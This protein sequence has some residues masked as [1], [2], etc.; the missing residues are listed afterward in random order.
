VKFLSSSIAAML[1]TLSVASVFG[2]AAPGAA[3]AAPLPPGPDASTAESSASAGA[4]A[5]AQTSNPNLDAQLDAARR[6]LEEAARQVAELS[7][8]R[9]Q[10]VI[11]QYSMFVNGPGRAIIG[12][13][14][15]NSS[16]SGTG[17][18]SGGARVVDVSPGGPAAEAGIR[19]GDV[20]TAVNG[21]DVK[22]ADPARQ[23][24]RLVRDVKPESKVRIEVSRN[25]KAQQFTLTARRGPGF[26]FF[27]PGPEGL[28][29]PPAPAAPP[30]PPAFPFGPGAMFLAQGPLADMELATLTPRLGSY[31]GTDKG[32]LVVRAPEDGA[33]KLEDGDV[34][35]SI[36][37]RVPTSGPHATRILASYQPGEK[38]N[39]RVVRERK[40]MDI[41]ATMPDRP[42][43]A[44]NRVYFR[45]GGFSAPQTRG[46]VIIM[47]G[48]ES[49]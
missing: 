29:M 9:G 25:G 15:E 40:R 19:A 2:Q 10:A 36:D 6:R 33:L 14:L 24:A 17:G 7:A 8:Q 32:I 12:V 41:T 39:L 49:I 28:E 35:L 18:G 48:S 23:V 16:G 42:Q 11:R 1:A 3:P 31:F 44:R 20:I 26:E 37:G 22:G 4:S 47:R 5:R 45:S 34:I 13:Q 21:T 46:R 30:A 27:G 38:I 43:R